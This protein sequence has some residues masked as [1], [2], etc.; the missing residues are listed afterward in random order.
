[1]LM[2]SKLVDITTDNA[3]DGRGFISGR[4]KF[5]LSAQRPNRI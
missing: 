1:M 4:G 2:R 3:L 5:Y